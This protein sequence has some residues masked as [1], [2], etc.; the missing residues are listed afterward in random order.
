MTTPSPEHEFRLHELE[1]LFLLAGIQ[2]PVYWPGWIRPD[3]CHASR[4]RR[5]LAVGDAKATEVPGDTDTLRRLRRYAQQADQW[6]VSGWNVVLALATPPDIDGS[7]LATLERAAGLGGLHVLHG[8]FFSVAH[9]VTVSW[10]STGRW[11]DSTN[12]LFSTR[13]G[14]C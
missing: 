6:K 1:T 7:W 2:R 5:V 8:E 10:V 4:S 9:D 12:D 14:V 3:V 11:T 13:F